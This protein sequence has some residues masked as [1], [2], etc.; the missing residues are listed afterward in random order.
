MKLKY[1]VDNL[2]W[3]YACPYNIKLRYRCKPTALSG[4]ALYDS[5][6]RVCVIEMARRAPISAAKVKDL[7]LKHTD[8]Y[9]LGKLLKSD[10]RN[11]M[12]GMG[13]VK[14]NTINRFFFREAVKDINNKIIIDLKDYCVT[15]DTMCLTHTDIYLTMQPT[16]CLVKGNISIAAPFALFTRCYDKNLAL[17]NTYGKTTVSRYTPNRKEMAKDREFLNQICAVLTYSVD[18]NVLFPRMGSHCSYCGWKNRC[19]ESM[20]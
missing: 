11:L 10:V 5:V 9:N 12:L 16:I 17:I 6:F 3:F 4:A 13:A 19:K 20:N 2:M 18:N 8:K 1:D 14:L 7:W 15:M